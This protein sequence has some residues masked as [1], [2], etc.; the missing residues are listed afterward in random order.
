MMGQNS[1]SCGLKPS[2]W[3]K[4]VKCNT[5]HTS[6]GD[7]SEVEASMMVRS[8]EYS[9]CLPTKVHDEVILQ[10]DEDEDQ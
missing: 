9:T 7:D 2:G 5:L 8:T 6:T 10:Q 1:G 3:E 4:T